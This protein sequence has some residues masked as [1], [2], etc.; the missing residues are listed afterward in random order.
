MTKRFIIELIIGLAG[1][2]AVLLFG[3]SGM[4]VLVLLVIY[5]F[6]RK[7]K[8]DE[9]ESQLFNKVG[10][11]TAILTLLACVGIYLA[12]DWGVNGY[13]IGEHW[14]LLAVYS[15]LIAH[16]MAGLVIFKKG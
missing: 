9:R 1:I 14:L 7:K 5:P 8:V 13:K 15:F 12:S 6:V 3:N 11:I 10:N 4:T 16:G 2:A